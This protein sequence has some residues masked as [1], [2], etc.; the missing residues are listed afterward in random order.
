MVVY[1]LII[2]YIMLSI[3]GI[4]EVNYGLVA[5]NVLAAVILL[6]LIWYLMRTQRMDFREAMKGFLEGQQAIIKAIK[7]EGLRTRRAIGHTVLNE[8][9]TAKLLQ[10]KMWY[11]SQQKLDYIKEVL[12]NNHLEDRE[13]QVKRKVETE[14]I[15]LSGLYVSDMNAFV[16]PIGELGTWVRE[17]LD[18]KSF[19]VEVFAIIFRKQTGNFS[20]E[21]NINVKLSDLSVLMKSVQNRLVDEL[22]QFMDNGSN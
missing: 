12:V 5:E 22:K 14:L 17:N 21:E 13:E 18:M 15:R 7:I 9:Q 3:P 4:G 1:N 6:P 10:E 16:T 2:F 8:E 19:L 20:R 11:V